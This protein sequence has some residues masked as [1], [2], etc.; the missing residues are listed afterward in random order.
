MSKENRVEMEVVAGLCRIGFEPGWS[1]GKEDGA[2]P[3]IHFDLVSDY[4]GRQH[5]DGKY[6]HGMG[7]I[8]REDAARLRDM[9]E[10]FLKETCPRR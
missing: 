3:G 5:P 8:R 10:I 1:T 7:V 6:W 2:N 9:L 4:P